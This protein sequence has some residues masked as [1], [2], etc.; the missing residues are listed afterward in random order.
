[1]SN[2]AKLIGDITQTCIKNKVEL[3]IT[4]KSFV[5]IEGIKCPGYFDNTTLCVAGGKK[6]WVDVLVH[7]S[8]H[9]DQYIER[10]P[11]YEKCD[12]GILLIEK[13]L[14]GKLK[15]GKRVRKAFEDTI[16]MELD[17]EQRTVKKIKKY[18]L[19]ISITNYI[20]QVNSYLLSYWMT[21]KNR[22]WYPFPY[23]NPKIVK[24]MP[25]KFLSPKEYVAPDEKY[26]KFFL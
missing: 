20:Q 1:M 16:L 21:H 26:L 19:K 17:C 14:A 5:E 9:L 7:E 6:D 25:K 8:C 24:N 11:I 4:S 13:W 3:L 23:N 18:K 15:D 2:L 10:V 22:E 12:S